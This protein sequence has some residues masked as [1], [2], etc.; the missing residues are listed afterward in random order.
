M[1]CTLTEGGVYANTH[2]TVVYNNEL[3]RLASRY[4]YTY[5]PLRNAYE[6]EYKDDGLH[7]K[8]GKIGYNKYMIDRAL[9]LK[10]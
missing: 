4:H 10:Y 6:G 5:V 9:S 2:D 3:K 7:F 1:G 8:H